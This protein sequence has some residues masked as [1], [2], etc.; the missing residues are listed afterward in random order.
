MTEQ[1][2]ATCPQCS[3]PIS[4]EDTIVFGHGRLGHLDC[5]RPGVLSV[6]ERTVLF[7]YCRDHTVA[8]CVGCARHFHLREVAALDSVGPHACPWCHTDLTDSIR[9][10]LYGCAILPAEARRRAQA[11]RDTAQI[12]VKQSLELHAAADVA[13]SRSGALCAPE[14][15]AA[16]HAALA[17]RQRI[18][19]SLTSFAWGNGRLLQRLRSRWCARSCRYCSSPATGL[20]TRKACGRSS[21]TPGAPEAAS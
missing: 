5:R 17:A 3:R 2:T 6:E 15:H 7:I 8:R 10:H 19:P 1:Q 4:P 11:A 18:A 14:H 9:T 16:V 13:R 21:T 12:L 20:S